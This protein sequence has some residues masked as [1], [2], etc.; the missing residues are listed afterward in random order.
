MPDQ[1]QVAR[2]SQFSRAH[3]ERILN[4]LCHSALRIAPRWED[5]IGPELPQA[6][7]IGEVLF[8]ERPVTSTVDASDP[9]CLSSKLIRPLSLVDAKRP[10]ARHT[11]P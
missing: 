7:R 4:P 9:F 1:S 5:P 3:E 10:I 2:L 6:A 8:A 11:K